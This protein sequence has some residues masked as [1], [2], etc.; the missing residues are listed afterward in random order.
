MCLRFPSYQCPRKAFP[1]CRW[2]YTEKVRPQIRRNPCQKVQSHNGMGSSC[3]AN[4]QWLW[5][6]SG[7]SRGCSC[8]RGASGSSRSYPSHASL[9]SLPPAHHIL[10]SLPLPRISLIQLSSSVNHTPLL[11]S[12]SVHPSFFFILFSFSVL[13]PTGFFFFLFLLSGGSFPTGIM[14]PSCPQCSSLQ[15]SSPSRDLWPS[16]LASCSCPFLW[17]STWQKRLVAPR[18]WKFAI[19]EVPIHRLL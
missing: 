10:V 11:L 3:E 14:T 17:L 5:D 16:D 13:I 12:A 7:R 2:L 4:H 19:F 6:S 8:G 1:R 18:I 9:H 15:S